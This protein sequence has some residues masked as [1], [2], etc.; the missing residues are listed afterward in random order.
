MGFDIIS[1]DK[2][3][4]FNP[5]DSGDYIVFD[6][7]KHYVFAKEPGFLKKMEGLNANL[8]DEMI[9]RYFGI[10]RPEV[11]ETTEGGKTSD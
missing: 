3:Q 8:R 2:Y 4:V 5:E 11:P 10:K 1:T 9:E 6:G 7:L